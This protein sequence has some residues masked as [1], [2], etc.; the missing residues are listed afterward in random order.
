[1]PKKRPDFGLILSPEDGSVFRVGEAF[2]TPD[3]ELKIVLNH[4][5]LKWEGSHLM[6][7]PSKRVARDVKYVIRGLSQKGLSKKER[8][9]E[10]K[11]E[12]KD[13][14]EAG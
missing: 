8:K 14:E 12:R 13:F 7:V 3:N 2:T 4:W 10:R 1:V 5:S 11:R 9:K 6:L